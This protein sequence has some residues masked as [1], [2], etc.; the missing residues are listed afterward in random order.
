VYD[1]WEQRFNAYL[2]Q[3]FGIRVSNNKEI[4]EP[5]RSGSYYTTRNETYYRSFCQAFNL[6]MEDARS[7]NGYLW[8][9]THDQTSIVNQ[10][11][12]AWGF[13]YRTGKGW[14]RSG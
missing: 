14:F 11:L 6:T 1:R 2:Y 13:T 4:P 9:K 5:W 7:F 12:R 8:I 3:N 10:Q